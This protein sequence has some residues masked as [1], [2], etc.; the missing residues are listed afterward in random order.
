MRAGDLNRILARAAGR[1]EARLVNEVM[2]RSQSQAVY[3]PDNIG[4][5]GLGAP[6]LLPLH[7]AHPPL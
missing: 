3:A 2:L 5:F 6:P 4:H 7:L 1:P